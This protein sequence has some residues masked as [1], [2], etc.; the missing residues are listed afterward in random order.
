MY[1]PGCLPPSRLTHSWVNPSRA[2]TSGDS[3]LPL[4]AHQKDGARVCHLE[5]HQQHDRL[6]RVL[7]LEYTEGVFG[8]TRYIYIHL[9]RVWLCEQF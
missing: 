7:A 4:A 8:L 6:Q 3:W 9:G 2:F 1:I 5:R